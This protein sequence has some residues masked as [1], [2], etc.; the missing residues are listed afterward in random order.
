[1]AVTEK[2]EKGSSEVSL[3][4]LP[5]LST[6][7]HL[8]KPPLRQSPDRGP[9][10]RVDGAVPGGRG[11]QGQRRGEQGLRLLFGF[12]FRFCFELRVVEVEVGFFPLRLSKNDTSSTLSYLP[13]R[14][15]GSHGR[16]VDYPRGRLVELALECV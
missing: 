14:R 15:P 8:S 6:P 3:A 16:G 1:M 4:S 13:L 10:R 9:Q 11:V 12:M 7:T 5:V 2:E